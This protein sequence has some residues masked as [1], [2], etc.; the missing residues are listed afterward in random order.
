M[1]AIADKSN[2]S[3]NSLIASPFSLIIAQSMK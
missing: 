1:I 3:N 2:I